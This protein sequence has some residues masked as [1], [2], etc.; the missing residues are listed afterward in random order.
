MC[1][2][3]FFVCVGRICMCFVFYSNETRDLCFSQPGLRVSFVVGG[4][5][6][7]MAKEEHKL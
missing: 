2:F 6:S 5:L 1:R 7:A 3:D 4:T